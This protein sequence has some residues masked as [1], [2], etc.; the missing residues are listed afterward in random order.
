MPLYP[1]ANPATYILSAS[2]IT[3]MSAAKHADVLFV[4]QKPGGENDL[5]A[6]CTREGI[7]HILFEDFSKA[8]PVVRSVVKGEMTL[9]QAFSIGKV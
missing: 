3:D 6:Y 7:R 8:L 1:I 5:A 4:K 9:D 2:L